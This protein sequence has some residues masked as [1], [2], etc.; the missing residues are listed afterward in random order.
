MPHFSYMTN[1][2]VSHARKQSSHGEPIFARIDRD[3]RELRNH[4]SRLQSLPIKPFGTR[5]SSHG[6]V[7]SL[8]LSRPEWVQVGYCLVLLLAMRQ[9]SHRVDVPLELAAE[10]FLL[11][12]QQ[13]RIR[14]E[15]LE[16]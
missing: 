14:I 6:S 1:A 9:L 7:P 13:E 12:V 11:D 15:N 4:V 3:L 10:K 2:N 8:P 16:V 5:T